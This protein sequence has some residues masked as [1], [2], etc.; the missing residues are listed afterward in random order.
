V[1]NGGRHKHSV[2]ISLIT[3]IVMYLGMWLLQAVFL[4]AFFFSRR[5]DAVATEHVLEIQQDALFD[6]TKYAETRI[7]WPYIRRVTL[8]TGCVVI[9]VAHGSAC[10]VPNRA[11]ASKQ[12]RLQFVATL[13]EKM[14]Q[15]KRKTTAPESSV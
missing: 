3:A 5:N 13:R 1:F 9:F 10:W 6:A 14:A 2:V 11:F 4:A 12:S 8:R 7:F 15:T